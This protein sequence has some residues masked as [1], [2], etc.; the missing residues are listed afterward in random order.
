MRI[1]RFAVGVGSLAVAISLLLPGCAPSTA[2]EGAEIVT[3]NGS[4]P[5]YP[6][7]PA[8]TDEPG[9]NRI[10][11][12]IFAGLVF[13]DESG[14]AVNDLAE[15]IEHNDRN[16]IYTVTIDDGATFTDG[17]DVTATSFVDAWAWAALA[18]NATINRHYFSDIVG[19]SEDE[20][21]SLVEE[22][23]LVVLDD[24]SFEIHLKT[25][26]SDFAQR[27]GH[28]AFSP[29]PVV[30]FDDPAAFGEYPIG[31]GPYMLDGPGAWQHQERIELIVNP[32]YEGARQPENG[33]LTM[34]FYDSLDIAYTDL[35]AGTLDVL[36]TIPASARATYKDELG[37]RWVDQPVTTLE[38][39]RIPK[40]LPHFAGA[41]G[42]LRR[43][44]LSQAIDR[45]GIAE[46]VFGGTR[47]PAR[48]FTS[49]ALDGFSENLTGA[50]VL[51]FN[52]DDAVEKWSKAD[53]LSPWEGTLEIAY[54]ADGGHEEWVDA[55]AE[56]IRSVLGIDVV[57]VPYP[58]L[59]DL[60][61]GIE[62]GSIVSAYRVGWRADYPGV[63]SFIAPLYATKGAANDGK[64]A[65]AAFEAQLKLGARA[66]TSDVADD[67]YE[68]AQEI[69][70]TDLPGIPLWN[71]TIQAGYGDGVDNVTFDWHG[72]P[73]YYQVT[74]RDG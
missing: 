72:T 36:D 67:A 34:M 26:L 48:D 39:L 23:G 58:T 71:T 42:A 63:M 55:V 27:L 12:A 18:E 70:L 53:A 43:A 69:L 40:N 73:L 45:A 54:N 46:D 52:S 59:S 5:R 29:L 28:I 49:P 62:D 10:L 64:Y 37:R 21:V 17:E 11:D 51:R 31:N 9:G 4:E 38:S 41:E 66:K 13:Y 14:A 2:P 33:G 47:I 60:K 24:H 32:G 61:A 16:T 7:I 74:K 19:Y 3:V 35:L 30:F 68:N 6:L 44:A 65:S 57:G 1:P 15:S 50:E 8:S 20:D 56:S 22:G 25:P